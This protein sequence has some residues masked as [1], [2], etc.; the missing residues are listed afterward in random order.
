LVSFTNQMISKRKL[1]F[2]ILKL[3]G[4]EVCMKLRKYKNETDDVV[5]YACNKNIRDVKLIRF[6]DCYK[7]IVSYQNT[8]QKTIGLSDKCAGL[9]LGVNNVVAVSTNVK[10][11]PQI[12]Y[13][14][15]PLKSINYYYN[16]QKSK[17]QSEFDNTTSKRRKKIIKNKILKLSRIRNNKIKHELHQISSVIVNQLSFAGIYHLVIGH[18]VGWKQETMMGKKN[19]QNFVNIPHSTL[20][21]MLTYKWRR[22]GGLVTI[23]EESYTSKCSFLDMEDLKKNS[24]YKGR[25]INRGLF[26]TSV[27]NI[28]NADINGAANILRKVVKDAWSNWTK[29]DLIMGFVVT[30]SRVTVGHIKK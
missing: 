30:P 4:L 28:I 11:M 16:K 20:I 18:N 12:L 9:D 19:N 25:R 3:T 24:S 2:D 7:L 10:Q 6:N 21:S 14:G 13:N 26:K 15:K 5:I 22:L 17:L 29:E 27:G 23:I 8:K 1:K